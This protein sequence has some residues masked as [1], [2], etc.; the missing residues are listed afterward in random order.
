[1]VG[2]CHMAFQSLDQEVQKERV[3]M[4]LV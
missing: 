4:C 2:K 3:H 1:M